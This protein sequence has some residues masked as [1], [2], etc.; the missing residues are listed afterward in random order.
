MKM[1]GNVQRNTLKSLQKAWR[2]TAQDQFVKITR[3]S[4]GNRWWLK[5]FAQCMKTQKTDKQSLLF[6]MCASFL[7]VGS[8][9]CRSLLKSA[10]N[11]NIKKQTN[12][13]PD[14]CN[15]RLCKCVP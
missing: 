12:K 10:T 15:I 14:R 7:F 9:Q 2:A 11:A 1:S 4:A 8:E 13:K 6:R 3:K 5:C